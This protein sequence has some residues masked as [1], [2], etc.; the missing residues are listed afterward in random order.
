M[1]AA[2]DLRVHPK[3]LLGAMLGVTYGS[4]SVSENNGTNVRV[5]V[6]TL[7]FVATLG[8]GVAP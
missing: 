1:G 6:P 8:P 3:L 2:Y 5:F 7:T 4:L